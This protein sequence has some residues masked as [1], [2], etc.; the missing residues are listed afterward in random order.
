MSRVIQGVTD[1]V[2]LFVL[3][4]LALER[5]RINSVNANSQMGR[6]TV[7]PLGKQYLDF[8]CQLGLLFR[9]QLS[10]NPE[11]YRP[12]RYGRDLFKRWCQQPKPALEEMLGAIPQYRLHA[13]LMLAELLLTGIARNV[14]MH[15]TADGDH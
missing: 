11:S 3:V 14:N 9:E 5:G 15:N 13:E 2:Q 8:A 10:T 7:S 1:P 4:S 6:V 12:T